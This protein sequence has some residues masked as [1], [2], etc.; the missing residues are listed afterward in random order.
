MINPITNLS[1]DDNFRQ[2]IVDFAYTQVSYFRINM[3]GNG[4]RTCMLNK[5][6]NPISDEVRVFA[7]QCYNALGI[8]NIQDE[9]IFGNFIGFNEEGAFVQTHV[10]KGIG[11]KMH[12]RLNFLIQKPEKG[13]MPVINDVVYEVK[14]GACWKNIASS[15]RH[16]TTPV[17]GC[18]E[19]IVLSLGSLIEK[20]I[21]D[22]ILLNETNKLP[23]VITP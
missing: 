23:I 13:G 10:D 14:E 20:S 11:T 3:L 9:P 8:Y 2:K 19:R 6:N 17:V 12:V 21:V 22:T 16:G 7:T 18:R 5:I 1:I 15:W 4:R